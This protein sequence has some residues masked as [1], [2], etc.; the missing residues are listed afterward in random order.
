MYC[1]AY[2][3]TMEAITDDL[4][5]DHCDVW[6]VAAWGA[7][8]LDRIVPGGVWG[9]WMLRINYK[10]YRG[11]QKKKMIS[12]KFYDRIT[13]TA[14]GV[15]FSSISVLFE[16]KKNKVWERMT[17]GVAGGGN[18]FGP[19]R[20]L[21]LTF[22]LSDAEPSNTFRGSNRTSFLTVAKRRRVEWRRGGRPNCV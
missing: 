18:S 8:V 16:E 1:Y 2:L 11:V 22:G 12:G 10:W 6:K 17:E 19:K 21:L 15:W 3:W 9:W 20:S 14:P 5:M 13:W 4:I 7:S